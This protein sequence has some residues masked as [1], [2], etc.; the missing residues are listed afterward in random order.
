[1]L[2]EVITKCRLRPVLHL[3]HYSWCL[4][5]CS[6]NVCWLNKGLYFFKTGLVGR[7]SPKESQS[8][9]VESQDLKPL[10]QSSHLKMKPREVSWLGEGHP[11]SWC[12]SQEQH[13]VSWGPVPFFPAPPS[14]LFS[15]HFVEVN[16]LRLVGPVS[17][18]FES[19]HHAQ[20]S[21]G[22]IGI[23]KKHV[24]WR[25]TAWGSDWLTYDLST[26]L[27]AWVVTGWMVSSLGLC[28]LYSISFG[29]ERIITRTIANIKLDKI[30]WWIVQALELDFQLHF[31][32]TGDLTSLV[33]HF[34][35][36]VKCQWYQGLPQSIEELAYLKP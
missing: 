28:V 9:K 27:S 29:E 16:L 25:L 5:L 24:K 4:T 32:E 7:K 13:S 35:T 17:R 12:Q 1:M 23:L 36:P 33:P 8:C 18:A 19:P 10:G 22:D 20:Q 2:I 31:H 14:Q 3:W 11:E 6:V 21:V 15:S 34:L 26:H 30:F